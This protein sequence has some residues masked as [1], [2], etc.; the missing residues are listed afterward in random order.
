MACKRA[1]RSAQ[2]STVC[3][4]F[5]LLTGG[6]RLHTGFARAGTDARY[7]PLRGTRQNAG[8]AYKLRR[9]TSRTGVGPL[10][11]YRAIAADMDQPLTQQPMLWVRSLPACRALVDDPQPRIAKALAAASVPYVPKVWTELAYEAVRLEVSPEK[12]S[13]LDVLYAYADP[14]EALSFTEITGLPKQVW[15][16]GVAEE[17]PWAMTDMSVYGVIHPTTQDEDGFRTAWA[18]ATE[19]ARKYWQPDNGVRAAELLVAGPVQLTRRLELI[20]LLR[21]RGLV[22]VTDED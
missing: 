21:E 7:P 18:Q 13:R 16:G 19:A 22:E 2:E 3:S 10:M 6:A 14:L 5:G 12:P 15:E 11:V 4:A 20:P 8:M 9:P 17:V 1:A